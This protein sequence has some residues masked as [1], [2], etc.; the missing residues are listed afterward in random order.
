MPSVAEF[1]VTQIAFNPTG[2]YL[3]CG[4]VANT[5]AFIELDDYIGVSR[6]PQLA[7]FLDEYGGF[8]VF[9]VI[10]I[11]ACAAIPWAKI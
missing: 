7:R 5:V 11:I 8:I 1:T 6:F 9:L 3:A 2:S 10:I 4:S